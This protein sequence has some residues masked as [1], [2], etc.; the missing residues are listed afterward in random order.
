MRVLWSRAE[1]TVNEI[2]DAIETPRLARNTVLT[3]LGVLERKGA[4]KHTVAGRTFLY[5]ATIAQ[6]AAQKTALADVVARFFD[7]SPSLLVSALLDS[8]QMTA[9]EAASI[10]ALF[11]ESR[12]RK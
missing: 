2:V 9:Q 12:K 5:R 7:S 3:T 1:A 6:S 4:V 8:K 10:R 11:E